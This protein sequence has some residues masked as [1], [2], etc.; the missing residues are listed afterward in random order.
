MPIIC[1]GDIGQDFSG[2]FRVLILQSP[3][4]SSGSDWAILQVAEVA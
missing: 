2:S 1:I 3:E 4:H